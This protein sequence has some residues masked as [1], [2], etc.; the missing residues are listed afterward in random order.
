MIT[1]MKYNKEG[2]KLN[3]NDLN[4]SLSIDEALTYGQIKMPT[5]I[6]QVSRGRVVYKDS[7]IN[8]LSWH[9]ILT[10]ENIDNLKDL[11][12]IDVLADYGIDIE[13]I[14]KIQPVYK[15]MKKRYDWDMMPIED[16]KK[17][18]EYK[19]A[20][21]LVR[22]KFGGTL[23][24]GS[25]LFDYQIE[26][27]AL[28][29]AK[30]RLLIAYDMGLGKTR[31]SIVGTYSDPANKK[32]LIVTMS[33][34]INDWIRELEILGLADDYIILNTPN[35]LKSKKRIHIVSYEKWATARYKKEYTAKIYNNCPICSSLSGWHKNLQYCLHCK[36]KPKKE[37][38]ASN[39][40]PKVCPC[41]SINWVAGSEFCKC[42]G[43]SVISKKAE[44]LHAYYKNNMY[45]ACI[46]DEIQFIKNGNSI[47]SKAVR[48][49]N[50]KSRIGLSG[51]PAENGA[52]DL[53][54]ILLWITGGKSRFEDPMTNRPY[55]KRRNGE[56]NFR[57]Y[58]GGG[59]KQ[60]VL[61]ATTVKIRASHHKDLW[62]LLDTLMIRKTKEDEEVKEEVKVPPPNHIRMHLEMT[63][64]DKTL[65]EKIL[66]Q[67]REWYKNELAKKETMKV[68]GI[69]Y[70]INSIEICS[71]I[72]KLR[73]AAS[74][75]WIFPEYNA[76]TAEEPTKITYLKNKASE[77]IRK[78]NKILVFTSHRATAE[79][80][81]ILLD[82]FMP[83]VSAG[84]IH[85]GV[86]MD[87][88]FELMRR[89]QDPNDDLSILVMTIKSGAESYTLTQA[90]AVFIYDLD[91]NGKKLEQCYSRAVRLGQ[92][93]V[94]DIHWLI[95]IDTIDA[96]MHGLI[97][98]KVG[99]VD[100]AIDREQFDFKEVAKQFEGKGSERLTTNIDYE[101]FAKQML[102][103]GTKRVDVV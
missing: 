74:C 1:K 69:N 12:A 50:T 31:T 60:R 13:G 65:Y 37:Y 11:P 81:G 22:E 18:K 77:Y 90:K 7:C 20:V 80:L 15:A 101:L 33:R 42:C 16:I 61:D 45:Q 103:R 38:Y 95:A 87:Y 92:K 6:K 26:G 24:D 99:G 52:E 43:F 4:T 59:S 54:Y 89:F 8:K 19:R 68:S 93:D 21:K 9:Y 73:K 75:P 100:L 82:G 29:I 17:T 53:F 27:A 91:F 30:K 76:L 102:G 48:K 56:E 78:G 72:D 66:D 28:I 10:K 44:G 67:F 47:R 39:D 88:R 94:V 63:K 98:S 5:K 14:E 55:S 2:I 58:Y 46:V 51:T 86:R 49:I 35:D 3:A 96:N 23:N 83:R 71:W 36:S 62:R 84:F 40:L 32:I 79:H 97:I 64:A 34:N 85:G 70:K 57:A 41:C 25:K